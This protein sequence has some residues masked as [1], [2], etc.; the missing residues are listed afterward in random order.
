[1]TGNHSSFQRIVSSLVKTAPR[2]YTPEFRIADGKRG[3]RIFDGDREIGFV[4]TEGWFFFDLWSFS[5]FEPDVCA[6]AEVHP[7]VQDMHTC[8]N[9]NINLPYTHATDLFEDVDDPF[10]LT[11]IDWTQSS[12]DRLCLRISWD[13]PE[14]QR[15]VYEFECRYDPDWARYR[16][17]LNVDCWKLKPGGFEPLNFM[18][19]GALRG[20][21]KSRWSHSVYDDANH[22]LRRIVHSNAL[23]SATDYGCPIGT[24]RTKTAP[25][26]DAWIAYALNDN[27]NPAM[28]VHEHNVSMVFATC[29]QLFDEHLIWRDAALEQLDGNHFHFQ[30]HTEFVNIPPDLAKDLLDH[31]QDPPVP[32]VWRMQ[33]TALPFRLGTVNDLEEPIDVWEEENCPVLVVENDV[34]AP[35]QWISDQGRSGTRSLRFVG[36]SWHGWTILFPTGAVCEVEPGVRY[37]FSAWVKTDNVQRFARLEL[38]SYEY[39]YGNKIDVAHS[40]KISDTTD[41]T[42]ISVELQSTDAA[43]AMPV[44]QLYGLGTAWFDDLLFEHV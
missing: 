31:A 6:N 5:P 14:N 10:A 3:K 39:T 23:F 13:L 32:D 9:S 38:A 25:T 8:R 28:L 11:A 18:M 24:W 1:M 20:W 4:H 26:Q 16:Y 21:T 19:V 41:W 37:R 40:L 44:L 34:R 35:V 2:D 17:F 7:Y 15:L 30:M 29:S 36:N 42:R 43:Y 27:C 12:G 22:D 33:R